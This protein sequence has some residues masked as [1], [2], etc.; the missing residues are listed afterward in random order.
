MRPYFKGFELNARIRTQPWT[1]AQRDENEQY[2][3]LRS[4]PELIPEVLEDYKPWH[5]YEAVQRFYE[6][7]GWAN[8]ETS[9]FQSND[10][11][12]KGPSENNQREKFRKKL[13][14]S[15]RLMLFF[16]SLDL[17]LSVESKEFALRNVKGPPDY[18]ANLLFQWLVQRSLE[19]IGPLD[20]DSIWT[21]VALE[22]CPVHYTEASGNDEDK[23]GHQVSY[24]FWAW[25]DDE[26]E[27]ME[28]LKIVV[29]TMSRCLK[30]L[31]DELP[32]ALRELQ[33]RHL[34]SANSPQST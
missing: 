17:N 3:D 10:C 7:L 21:C 6:L 5:H 2:H 11:A 34:S 1:T 25:G 18:S 14:C 26:K 15:G 32:E 9:R 13:V 24:E 23:F 8:G 12:F 28:N 16:R 30:T 31:S 22:I 29:G 19:L 33:L 27:T 20:K 4:H